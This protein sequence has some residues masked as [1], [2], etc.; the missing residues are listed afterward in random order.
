MINFSLEIESISSL[1]ISFFILL[2][3]IFLN[4]NKIFTLKNVRIKYKIIALV[5]ISIWLLTQAMI[6]IDGNTRTDFIPFEMA[7]LGSLA[8]LI[9]S[10][11]ILIESKEAKEKKLAKIKSSIRKQKKVPVRIREAVHKN[12]RSELSSSYYVLSSN[13]YDNEDRM[14]QILDHI[15]E[16]G[17]ESI[18]KDDMTFLKQYS[19]EL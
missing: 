13:P 1:G 7:S 5:L 3:F 8:A 12:K 9:I 2:S 15:S 19:N 11:K 16:S 6:S 14:N 17:I 10:Q 18:Q 4:I